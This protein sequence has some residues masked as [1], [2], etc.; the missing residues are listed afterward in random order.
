MSFCESVF[1]AG[2]NQKTVKVDL[3]IKV[4]QFVHK[5]MWEDSRTL[6]KENHQDPRPRANMWGQPDYGTHGSVSP[7]NVGSPPPWRSHLCHSFKSVWS[8][9]LELLPPI[10]SSPIEAGPTGFSSDTTISHGLWPGPRTKAG[11]GAT[12][13]IPNP[14]RI[15]QTSQTP[16]GKYLLYLDQYTFFGSD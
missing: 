13:A 9:G 12:T 1:L 6:E 7:S 15:G 8:E 5:P 3:F 2:Y 11:R 16:I 10:Y 4:N 14:S